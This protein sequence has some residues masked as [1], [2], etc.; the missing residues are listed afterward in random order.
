MNK[1]AKNFFDFS[2]L[3]G[4]YQ[5]LCF[6][7]NENK[8]V[9]AISMG[10]AEK[11]AILSS[12]DRPVLC[13]TSDYIGATRI[14]KQLESLFGDGAVLL[15]VFIDNLLY[16]KSQTIAPNQERIIALSKL[17][18]GKAK[19]V[20]ASIDALLCPLPNRQRFEDGKICIKKGEDVD[21][22]AL[23]QKL[24]KVGYRKTEIIASAGDFSI[25]GDI[26]DV[27]SIPSGP[28]RIEL[29]G[30]TI[31]KIAYLNL[32]NL[33]SE[34]SL[35]EVEI[36][37][38]TDLL[39]SDEEN[40]YL[41]EALYYLKEKSTEK[42]GG[43]GQL[44][45]AITDCLSRLEMGD[46]A[47][48]LD[49]LFPLIMSNLSSLFD[50]LPK[51]T[52]I[53]IDEGKMCYDVIVNASSE[54]EMRHKN[55]KT[56]KDALNDKETGFFDST[57]VLNQIAKYGGV[58]HQRI[59][60]SNRFYNP[61]KV[62]TFKSLQLSR[63][64]HNFPELVTDLQNW[65]FN[66][67]DIY[68]L[69]G[70]PDKVRSLNERLEA[71]DIFFDTSSATLS[72]KGQFILPVEFSGGFVLA[73]E[74][75]VV[76]S[77]TD[78]FAPK[79][80]QQ[81]VVAS[82]KNVF[83]VP[84]QGD[85]VVHSFHGI[86][87]CEGVTNLSSNFGS[88]DYV[89]VR[90]AGDDKLYVPIDSLSSLERYSGAEAPKKLSKIGGVEFAKVKERVKA[91]VKKIAFDLTE[92]Y[93]KREA[94]QGFA[95]SPDSSL[96][97]DFENAFAYIETEDQLK[98]IAEIKKDMESH[99]VMDRLLCGDVGFGKTEVAMRAMFKAVLDGKQVA[100][101]APTTILSEQHY[102]TLRARLEPF[103][104]K[105]AV[106]NRFSSAKETKEILNELSHGRIDVLCGTHRVL[107]DDVNFNDIGL[108]VLDEE[109]KFGVEDKEKLKNKYP[110]VDFLTLSA[111][112]IPRTLHMSLSGIR[113]VS[114]I[115]TPP[116]ERL[117]IQTFVCEYSESLLR[118]ACMRE[119]ARGGQVFI[120]FNRV[121]KIY[122]FA[123]EVRKVLPE[124]RVLVAHGQLSGKELEDTVYKFYKKDADILI[125]TTIIENGI[126]I[127]NANTLIVYDS[128]N[129]G[130]SQ[131]Y[132]IRGRVGRGNRTAFAYFTYKLDKILSEEAYKRLDAI[133]EFTEFGSGFKISMR[134]L[135]I[136]GGGNILGAEQHGFME[137]VGY[138]M[139]AK[140]LADAIA[141][142]KGQK[143]EEK[144]DTLMRISIDAY[145]PES[146]IKEPSNRM[147]TYKNISAISSLDE[148]IS[149]QQD[150]ENTF[151]AVPQPVLNLMDIA[152][153]KL[154]ASN[155]KI[156]EIVSTSAGIKFIFSKP[157]DITGSAYLGEAL[158]KFK[159]RCALE[160]GLTP[161][162]KMTAG[163]DDITNL[164]DLTAFLAVANEAK[165]GKK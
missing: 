47:F 8:K 91:S 156:V 65:K 12:V 26:V 62:L 5:A 161:M 59:T 139:Y 6:A 75:K 69:A 153:A 4:N 114:I 113:D 110:L 162:I 76:V 33:S 82:R 89:I 144:Q 25:R 40:E 2:S 132:Q 131:L 158:Y 148:K 32:D 37:P 107:S 74:K 159:D 120:L 138:E 142:I 141:E 9:S 58:V 39:L 1:R 51:D 71:N 154:L 11:V 152:Y 109:Q 103:G 124:A 123:E 81:A 136:R 143:V 151:G 116:S 35:N 155:L 77:T 27:F 121:E 129:F 52:V 72:S 137:K 64:Y 57:F 134:D 115:N 63:Y 34:A 165:K 38:N 111:T 44:S 83:S 43:G 30:D 100:F 14:H 93:A 22:E 41:T 102:N 135:E 118:D 23:K 79:K 95:F 54:I 55:L 122:H 149:L 130:L 85:Y 36:Y 3:G 119:L 127:E 29:F 108:V 70:T 140:L 56:N 61:E 48:S 16:K 31:D 24:V 128:D 133:R 46:R 105:V 147:T 13:L 96:Q 94:K 164:K 10:Q 163:K 80:S 66:N 73:S 68:L 157:E 45:L 84:R 90:Y 101:V 112:P 53:V 92:L 49:Y 19:A 145:V 18:S 104:V 17:V 15:P 99:K 67:F 97:R 150:F 117:P 78:L 50:Y 87:I 106:L 125:C 42:D 146:Y 7:L 160:L 20:V 86:G 21:F 28:I 126:D 88:K 60:N 98:S